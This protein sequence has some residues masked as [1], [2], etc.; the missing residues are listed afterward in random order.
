MAWYEDLAEKWADTVHKSKLSRKRLASRAEISP[1]HAQALLDFI[2]RDITP[3]SWVPD[4]T[5][6]HSTTD[7][8]TTVQDGKPVVSSREIVSLDDL[9]DSANVD[10]TVW[11]VQKWIANV[12]GNNRQVKAW[13]ERN[14]IAI[15]QSLLNTEKRKKKVKRLK[16]RNPEFD[17]CAVIGLS[18]F[19]WGKYSDAATNGEAY[20]RSIARKRLFDA[21]GDLLGK[22]QLFGRPEYILVPVGSDFFHV[23]TYQHT[24]TK[25]TPGDVDGSY[26]ELVQSG[27][28]L[29]ENWIDSLRKIAPVKIVMMA[30]NHDRSTGFSLLLYL[31]ALYRHCKDVDVCLDRQPRVYHRYGKNLIGFVH[32]DAVKKTKDLAGLM[33]NEAP[34]WS[35]CPQRTVYTGHLH[36]EVTETEFGV[37]RRQLPSLSGPDRWHKLHGHTMAPKSLPGYVH[38]K[39]HG[40]VGILYGLES[41]DG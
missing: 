7:T 16:F 32:G 14:P 31:E 5:V 17:Y 20:D 18:D 23:D 9:L 33:A 21:T 30:G 36:N 38:H 19:H 15:G 35:E 34:G 40:V 4:P 29:V 2:R 27:F 6:S 8:C 37:V 11:R 28:Q 41:T 12:W 26:M 10:K 13:L 25:G 1:L 3:P 24:T 22:L 39:E